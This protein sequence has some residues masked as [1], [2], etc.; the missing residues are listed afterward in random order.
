MT[1]WIVIYAVIA[2]IG[3]LLTIGAAKGHKVNLWRWVFAVLLCI[4]W[5]V[6]V[7]LHIGG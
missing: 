1:V 6:N 7:L 3:L 5:P 2:V 4:V